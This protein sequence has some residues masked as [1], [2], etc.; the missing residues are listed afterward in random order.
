M[1]PEI[2]T[3]LTP[4]P[5]RPRESSLSRRYLRV[6]ESWVPVGLQYFEDWPDRP[7]CGHFLG[8][9]HWYGLETAAGCLAFAAAAGSPEYDPGRGGYSREELQGIAVKG[10]R[11]LC[12]TH[13]T[14]PADCVRPARGLGRPENC[15][16]KWGERGLGFFKESQCGRT[17]ADLAVAA[18]LLADR[19]DDETWGMLATVLE[20]Y[21][22]RFGAMPPRNGVYYDTQM[23]E[24]GWTACG[25]AAAEC[26][27]ARAPQAEAWGRTAR[28]WMFCTATAPQDAGNRQPF[29]GEE[30]VAHLTGRTF[31]A[32]PDYL[33]ENHGMV[34][35]SYTATAVLFSGDLAITYAL[36][37]LPLPE[38]ARFN[39]Q[40]IYDQLKF[41][42][43]RTGSLH[44]V[45]GMDWPYLPPDP[46]TMTH[47]SA[48]VLLRDPDAAAFERRALSTLEARQRGNGGRLYDQGLAELVHDIQDP[49]IVRESA[50][51]GPAHT[52][53]LHR[54]LGDGPR[55]TPEATLERRLQGVRVYPHAGTLLHRHPHGQTSLAWRNCVMALPLNRDGLYTVAPASG[56]LLGSVTVKGL[57]DSHDLRSLQIE[58]HDQAFAAAL[59]LDRA[60]GSVRQ[61]ILFAGLPDGLSLLWE[62]LS[63]T[64]TLTVERVEQGFL[65]I[66]NE[67]FPAL[68]GNCQGFRVLHT[69]GWEERFAGYAD[70]DPASDLVRQLEAPGWLN[71]D[72]RLGII[73]HGTGRT[74]YHN[75]H[76]FPTWWAVADD[77]ILSRDERRRRVT[78][79][80]VIGELCAVLA[81]DRSRQQTAALRPVELAAQGAAAGLIAGEYLAAASFAPRDGQ[82]ELRASR[83]ALPLVPIFPGRARV[84]ARQV[85]YAL[86]LLA[87]QATLRRRLFEVEV[88]GLVEIAMA[89]TGEV[90]V[91]NRGSAS[92]RIRAGKRTWR[93]PTG[94]SAFL[95]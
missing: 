5:L 92:A 12:F 7:G 70:A 79:G 52:Y 86:A 27:L 23:E 48:A 69:A 39:R 77:L 35:P 76:H 64:R 17:I 90:L 47:A 19:V 40:R 83:A 46:G 24:N 88:D 4:P 66:I 30:T 80:A 51:V 22:G 43:D 15:G 9:C 11:Y 3:E 54:L 58:T 33:A 32:L 13:D 25:L 65:R 10:I 49:L 85:T 67:E 91:R 62:R 81:P 61:Q 1:R 2:L 71:L 28:R 31:T 34:H 26:L 37:G 73:Y 18:V 42:T 53:L 63:A 50:I 44:P 56:S 57:A 41:A 36:S 93:V 72:D 87:G 16:T 38:H 20:D 78:A 60:Q 82:V 75:R 74:V 55:P 95:A 8:G 68:T 94:G 89:E 14:G 6:L 59:V 84:T 29:A 45:Q 21:A